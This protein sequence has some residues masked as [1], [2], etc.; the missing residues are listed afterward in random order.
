MCIDHGQ[1]DLLAVVVVL[2][3]R[4]D[5]RNRGGNDLDSRSTELLRAIV[6]LLPLLSSTAP[7]KRRRIGRTEQKPD[8]GQESKLHGS[9]TFFI[10]SL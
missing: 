1:N 10:K 6:L 9:P 3:D 7:E 5:E 4:S 8:E 2:L